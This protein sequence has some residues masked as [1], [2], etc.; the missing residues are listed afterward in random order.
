MKIKVTDSSGCCSIAFVK[1]VT[2][3]NVDLVS[4]KFT[5]PSK[6]SVFLIIIYIHINLPVTF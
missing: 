3:N 6:T 1:E 5:L 4:L 2:N